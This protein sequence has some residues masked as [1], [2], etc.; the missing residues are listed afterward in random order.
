MIAERFDA[1]AAEIAKAVVGQQDAVRLILA[2]MVMKGHVLLEGVPGTG[3][4]LL[5]KALS[6]VTDGDYKRIQFTPDLMPS[7]VTGTNVYS[8]AKG[9][10]RFVPGPIFTDVL[11]ADE[12]NR[13]VPKTQSALLEAMEERQVTVDGERR[14]LS[15]RFVVLATENPVEFE[16]TYPLP[17]AQLD[18]FTMKVPITYPD[19]AG[20]AEVLRRH[21][22][23][24]DPHDIGALGLAKV[25]TAES[26]AEMRREAVAVRVDDGVIDYVRKLAQASRRQ[27]A[28]SLGVSTRAA[29][30]LLV[31][32]KVAAAGEGRDFVLPDDVKRMAV[33]VLAHRLILQ[34]EAEIDGLTPAGVVERV[35]AGVDVPR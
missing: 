8:P 1:A 21:A 12:I 31:A 11:L 22:A 28:L 19:E 10:F 9:E 17:E 4:T 15:D 14:M 26:L 16:G 23:G 33:P 25:M 27:E 2:A 30:N 32:A 3:K 13:A 6:A 35:L 20:E 18:R 24:F 7:D 34:P 29:A 5:A